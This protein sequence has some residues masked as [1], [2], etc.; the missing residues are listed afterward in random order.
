MDRKADVPAFP[1]SLDQRRGFKEYLEAGREI[2]SLPERGVLVL[3][4]G[5]IVHNLRRV[6]WNA[7]Q[8]RTT[9]PWSLIPTSSTL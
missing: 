3:G 2:Q 9:G 6:D 5:N 8:G 1:L 4:S 7:P